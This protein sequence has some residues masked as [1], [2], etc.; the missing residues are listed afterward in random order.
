MGSSGYSSINSNNI[1]TIAVPNY[2]E[3][4]ECSVPW[5]TTT[6][7]T[8]PINTAQTQEAFALGFSQVTGVIL[9]IYGLR[10]LYYLIPRK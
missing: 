4:A 6:Q 10:R 9:L 5:T 1:G 8:A 7:A 3:Y 2:A